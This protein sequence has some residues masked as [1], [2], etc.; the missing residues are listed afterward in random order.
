[1]STKGA[2]FALSLRG[3]EIPTPSLLILNAPHAML[4]NLAICHAFLAQAPEYN[5][6]MRSTGNTLW[7][8]DTAIAQFALVGGVKVLILNATKYSPTT[9][10][11]MSTLL[12][13]IKESGMKFIT[14][15]TPNNLPFGVYDLA[16]RLDKEVATKTAKTA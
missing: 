5:R 15:E 3:N 4:S 16:S 13:A 1:M 7:S 12:K 2:N 14:L 8:Y 10:R 11:Q 9:G 6:N